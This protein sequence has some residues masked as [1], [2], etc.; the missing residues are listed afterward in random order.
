VTSTDTNADARR[1]ERNRKRRDQRR[2]EGRMRMARHA[3]SQLVTYGE[4]RDGRPTA[5]AQ[6]VIWRTGC[7]YGGYLKG[8]DITT[9]EASVALR[10][11]LECDSYE[12]SQAE[13]KQA[14]R[15]ILAA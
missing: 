9:D 6:D 7:M 12:D 15:R 14:A 2:V 1:Q 13:I 8:D 4:W 3:A 5:T 10:V 11:V